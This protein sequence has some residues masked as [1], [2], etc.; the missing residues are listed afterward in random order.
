MIKNFGQCYQF[1]VLLVV[2]MK[3]F[4]HGVVF[5]GCKSLQ[6]KNRKNFEWIGLITFISHSDQGI[7][8]LTHIR[9]CVL[10]NV[11]WVL[12]LFTVQEYSSYCLG[13][14]GGNW[15]SDEK[16]SWLKLTLACRDV[17]KGPEG[18]HRENSPIFSLW[19]SD[20][21]TL[22]FLPVCHFSKC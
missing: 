15:S 17:V 21:G 20:L 10:S 3:E 9:L 11:R 2:L 6:F 16:S 8:W 4:E 1:I 18:G 13:V 22:W 5:E 14:W 19:S 7:G 12:F